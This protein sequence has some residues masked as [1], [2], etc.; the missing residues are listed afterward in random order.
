LVK[1]VAAV[2]GGVWI[3]S[4]NIAE[5]MRDDPGAYVIMIA[6]GVTLI[7]AALRIGGQTLS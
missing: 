1:G 2:G 3:L 6:V 4:E 5:F 7:L